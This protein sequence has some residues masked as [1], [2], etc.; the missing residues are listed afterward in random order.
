MKLTL[1][2]V[3]ANVVS[4]KCAN[5]SQALTAVFC[6]L[7]IISH[8]TQSF[9]HFRE[10]SRMRYLMFVPFFEFPSAASNFN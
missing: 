6:A 8:A 3:K 9:P 5:I 10:K 2:C 4:R 7:Q 1:K